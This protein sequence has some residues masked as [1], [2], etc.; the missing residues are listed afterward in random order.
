M[1]IPTFIRSLPEIY[2]G[3][4]SA[5]HPVDRRFRDLMADVKGMASENKLA[6][7]NHAASLL[8]PGEAYLEVGSFAGLS[9]IAAML[10]N[11]RSPFYAVEN[12]RGFG[13]ERNDAVAALRDNLRRWGVADRLT[14]IEGDC[15]EVL[16]GRRAPAEP[17]GVYFYDGS[18]GRLAHYLAIGTVEPLLADRALVLIDDTSWSRVR[19]ATHAYVARHPGYRLLLDMRSDRPGEPRWWNGM[20]AYEFRRVPRGEQ[21]RQRG[22]A[23]GFDIR[24][25]RRANRVVEPTMT[26]LGRAMVRTFDGRPRLTAAARRLRAAASGKGS[27]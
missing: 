22:D 19:S 11:E 8:E 16:R 10:G 25:R 20:Q 18:H 26:M 6:L 17:V 12:F 9:I 14:L 2:G 3:S 4:L 23:A 21:R 24:W 7:L 27:A 5:A 15:F 1:D 13:M